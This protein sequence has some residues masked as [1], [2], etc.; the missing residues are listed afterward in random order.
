MYRAGSNVA[1]EHCAVP[2]ANSTYVRPVSLA[3]AEPSVASNEPRTIGNIRNFS[4][5]YPAKK[6]LSGARECGDAKL[7]P[8]CPI[9]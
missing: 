4:A 1:A 3:I 6:S 8:S 2:R 9:V 7:L 5:L